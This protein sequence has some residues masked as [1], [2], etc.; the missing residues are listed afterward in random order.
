MADAEKVRSMQLKKVWGCL[1]AKAVR[2][3]RTEDEVYA[4]AQ[5]LLGYA[6]EDID[7]L[8]EEGCTYGEFFD[9]APALNPKRNL[10]TGRICGVK[11]E[12]IEDPLH[13]RYARARQDGR[14]AGP[15]KAACQSSQGKLRSRHAGRRARYLRF[16][17][18]GTR[19]LCVGQ[20]WPCV[21]T[22]GW[23]ARYRLA[24]PFRLACPCCPVVLP[25]TFRCL[26]WHGRAAC[27]SGCCHN[28]GLGHH[29][30]C[31]ICT[32]PPSLEACS[33]LPP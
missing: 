14:R 12:D 16:Q 33:C 18:A 13:A 27:T 8:A 25:R 20:I 7:R 21:C 10:V 22:A 30:L 11:V 5:W 24:H 4:V 19:E 26:L 31:C 17:R 15:R 28:S 6:R 23:S 2:K 32:A 9:K 1:V 3:G 29:A